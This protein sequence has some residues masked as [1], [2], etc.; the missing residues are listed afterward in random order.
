MQS[1]CVA[2]GHRRDFV[3][4]P[5]APRKGSPPA[6]R[7]DFRPIPTVTTWL[8]EQGR[9][10]MRSGPIQAIFFYREGISLSRV[11]EIS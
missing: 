6:A 8:N 1:G 5:A 11:S 4:S 9:V 10:N 7:T 2:P 3:V